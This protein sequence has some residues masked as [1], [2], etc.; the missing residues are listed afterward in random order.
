MESLTADD[1]VAVIDL[2]KRTVEAGQFKAAV[3]VSAPAKDLVWAA[4][5]YTA[6]VSVVEKNS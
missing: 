1:L 6:V 5:E 4:G 2:S 3:A